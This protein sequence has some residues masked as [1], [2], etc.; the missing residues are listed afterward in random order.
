VS[1]FGPRAP[2]KGSAS[3]EK[4][5]AAAAVRPIRCAKKRMKYAG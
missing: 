2:E 1:S 4:T 5:A 3:R